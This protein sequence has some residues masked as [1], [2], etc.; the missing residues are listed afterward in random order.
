MVVFRFCSSEYSAQNVVFKICLRSLLALGY[1]SAYCKA[2]SVNNY[3]IPLLQTVV[4]LR[5]FRILRR[6]Y[7]LVTLYMTSTFSEWLLYLEKRLAF[8]TRQQLS[9]EN[10]P[11][12]IQHGRSIKITDKTSII[13]PEA[14]GDSPVIW[15]CE[16]TFTNQWYK[17]A[18][19]L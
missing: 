17:C 13:N 18:S 8:C 14:N 12:L 3:E 4:F 6:H 7:L 11:W 5:H 19:I 16:K 9:K 15:N 1:R 10:V 2:T